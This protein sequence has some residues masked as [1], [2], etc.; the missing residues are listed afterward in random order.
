MSERDRMLFRQHLEAALEHANTLVIWVFI[1]LVGFIAVKGSV[2][3]AWEILLN[4]AA[5]FAG[6]MAGMNARW[7]AVELSRANAIVKRNKP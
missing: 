1:C 5:L 4:V 7:A 6:G 2:D 3:E